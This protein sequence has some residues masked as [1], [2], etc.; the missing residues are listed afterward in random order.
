LGKE[1]S[2]VLFGVAPDFTS[3]AAACLAVPSK[4]FDP[5]A[6]LATAFNRFSFLAISSSSCMLCR[7]IIAVS[8]AVGLGAF[9]DFIFIPQVFV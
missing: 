3:L 8:A 9:G 7:V 2:I 6:P 1:E 4:D 5:K